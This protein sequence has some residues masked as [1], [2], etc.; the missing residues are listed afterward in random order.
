MIN[1][2]IYLI[3]RFERKE[4]KEKL[5]KC[6]NKD[7]DYLKN[8]RCEQLDADIISKKMWFPEDISKNE[9]WIQYKC[10]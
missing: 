6:K 5:K 9:E 4:W 2:V 7:Y 8:K 1:S 10:S 3:Y